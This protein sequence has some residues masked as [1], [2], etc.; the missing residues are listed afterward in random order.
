MNN[1]FLV[2]LESKLQERTHYTPITQTSHKIFNANNTQ[3]AQELAQQDIDYTLN[4][5]A[6][7][8][9]YSKETLEEMLFIKI[10]N[11]TPL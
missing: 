7:Q 11:I 10:I 1:K 6:K 5:V 2:T 9:G 3:H 4:T 8:Q